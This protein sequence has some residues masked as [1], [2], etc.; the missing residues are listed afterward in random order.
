[1]D[2]ALHAFNE[3]FYWSLHHLTYNLSVILFG[4]AALVVLV[5]LLRFGLRYPWRLVTLLSVVCHLVT[6]GHYGLP[7][8]ADNLLWAALL[9]GLTLNFFIIL[10]LIQLLFTF[11][12]RARDK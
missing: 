7:S 1:M 11:T 8:E 4:T 10:R 5:Q 3:L 9:T 2:A 6:V 12:L